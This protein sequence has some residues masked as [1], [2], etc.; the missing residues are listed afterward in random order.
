[1]GR[2]QR[3]CLYCAYSTVRTCVTSPCLQ[4]C[5]VVGTR[6]TCPR[7]R[8]CP[9]CHPAGVALVQPCN[10]CI[11][12]SNLCR[13]GHSPITCWVPKL[14]RAH[15]SHALAPCRTPSN[16]SA[17][18]VLMA[19]GSASCPITHPYA[20][21]RDVV[22][23]LRCFMCRSRRHTDRLTTLQIY[24]DDR[25]RDSLTTSCSECRERHLYPSR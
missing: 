5:A 10:P 8:F 21:Y 11:A 15:H 1:M 3:C 14:T 6:P 16:P 9:I 4:P 17:L 24:G 25:L 23:G 19:P 12:P 18:S 20:D 7:L 2:V 22:S 13:L